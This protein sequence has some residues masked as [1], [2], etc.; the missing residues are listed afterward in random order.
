MALSSL[1]SSSAFRAP[2]SWSRA[3]DIELEMSDCHKPSI[4][5]K[6]CLTYMIWIIH[7]P[8]SFDL[9]RLNKLSIS[10]G[11]LLS[12]FA[13]FFSSDNGSIIE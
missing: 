13:L 9:I 1:D 7:A 10:N 3:I 8:S 11:N 2:T 12:L 6:F 5:V 4:A